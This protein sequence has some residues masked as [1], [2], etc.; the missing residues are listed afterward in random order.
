MVDTPLHDW[1]RRRL[2]DQLD[3]AQAAGFGRDAA[4]AVLIDLATS[5]VFNDAPPQEP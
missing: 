5:T 1:L 4:E 2:K 3:E